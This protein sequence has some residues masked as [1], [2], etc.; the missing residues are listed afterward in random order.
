MMAQAV[1][2]PTL[3]PEL[4]Y[5]DKISWRVFVCFLLWQQQ[6]R[7]EDVAALAQ[8]IFVLHFTS[9]SCCEK[10]MKGYYMLIWLLEKVLFCNFTNFWSNL[11]MKF[12][13]SRIIGTVS[14]YQYVSY[15]YNMLVITIHIS[16][17][18]GMKH[19]WRILCIHHDTFMIRGSD[20]S[21]ANRL[22]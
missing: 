14:P 19:S 22:H 4:E 7:S 6:Y 15:T 11:R 10:I 21:A 12:L 20:G 8:I 17:C 18:V 16:S 1:L 3:V 5:A 9:Q 13:L 2:G